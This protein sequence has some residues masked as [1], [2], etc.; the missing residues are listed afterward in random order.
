MFKLTESRA[1]ED[2][3]N[4]VLKIKKIAKRASSTFAG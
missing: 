4:S 2:F 3:D 1:L